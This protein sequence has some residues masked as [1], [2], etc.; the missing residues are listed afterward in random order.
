MFQN[1]Y[2]KEFN[3]RYFLHLDKTLTETF[4][5]PAVK[6]RAIIQSA[7]AEKDK[8]AEITLAGKTYDLSTRQAIIEF[9]N[10]PLVNDSFT[11]LALADAGH[12]NY[13]MEPSRGKGAKSIFHL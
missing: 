6:G 10:L 4:Y 8:K 1:A 11:I 9:L 12:G 3:F 2:L 13:G 5:A 7:L